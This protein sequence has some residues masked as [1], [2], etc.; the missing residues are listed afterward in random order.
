MSVSV[1]NALRKLSWPTATVAL[2]VCNLLMYV[3][4]QFMEPSFQHVMAL[5]ADHLDPLAWLSSMFLHADWW[6]LGLN[7]LFLWPFGL[8]VEARFG[9]ARTLALY[10]ASGIGA[11]LVFLTAHWGE[12]V[13]MI[14]S[15]GAIAGMMGI[16]LIAAPLGKLHILPVH[17]VIMLS[18]SAPGRRATFAVP[19]LGWVLLWVVSQIALASLDIGNV[20]YTAH[21][22]GIGAGIVLGLVLRS[23]V[24]DFDEAD[25]QSRVVERRERFILQVAQAWSAKTAGKARVDYHAIRSANFEDKPLSMDAPIAPHDMDDPDY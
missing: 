17:P 5:R 2:I 24:F 23:R 8:F 16:C 18:A 10:V 25:S 21:F 9:W 19:L 20:A 6:H 14:G 1:R 3:A 13:S 4:Q 7:M 22:G 12:H 15:S 11:A